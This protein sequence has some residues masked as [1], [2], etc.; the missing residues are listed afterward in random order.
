[1]AGA[2]LSSPIGT[3]GV[4]NILGTFSAGAQTLT[5]TT[6]G[7][8]SG[9][10]A[11]VAVLGQGTLNNPAIDPTDDAAFTR[12][13]YTSGGDSTV[14]S[15]VEIAYELAGNNSVTWSIPANNGSQFW[16]Y[17]GLL[18]EINAA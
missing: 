3:T 13:N 6:A 12:L 7:S 2:D 9:S 11:M 17:D 14:R 18:I 10:S 1:V 16:Y 8:P 15:N 4:N 5:V